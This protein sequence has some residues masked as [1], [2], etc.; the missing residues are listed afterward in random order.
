MAVLPGHL[1]MNRHNLLLTLSTKLVNPSA[2][3][4]SVKTMKLTTINAPL[5]PQSATENIRQ[6]MAI[7]NRNVAIRR[8]SLIH[9]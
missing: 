1:R 5:C 9:I 6:T 4:G 3:V 7:T 8:L 2:I